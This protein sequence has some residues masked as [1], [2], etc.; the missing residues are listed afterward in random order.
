MVST[1]DV[2]EGP[3]S[4]PRW[5]LKTGLEKMPQ[6]QLHQARATEHRIPCCAGLPSRPPAT[7]AAA[8][9]RL[10]AERAQ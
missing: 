10:P 6:T 1:P 5:L 7:R 2:P 4:I 8:P 9:A 3:S